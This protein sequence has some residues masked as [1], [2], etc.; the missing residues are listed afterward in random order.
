[1]KKENDVFLINFDGFFTIFNDDL[2]IGQF[3]AIVHIESKALVQVF[4]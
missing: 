2:I 4:N 3:T 1:V